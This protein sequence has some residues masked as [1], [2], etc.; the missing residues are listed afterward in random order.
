MFHNKSRKNKMTQPY[1][2]ILCSNFKIIL[3][4]NT[5]DMEIR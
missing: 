5:N 4:K 2:G 3:K 1:K